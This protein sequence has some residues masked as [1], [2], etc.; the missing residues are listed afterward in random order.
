MSIGD[1]LKEVRERQGASQAEFGA[2]GGVQKQAQLKYEKGV[3]CPDA[4]YLAALVNAGVDV[5]YVLTGERWGNRQEVLAD[6]ISHLPLDGQ[7]VQPLLDARSSDFEVMA[8]RVKD[9]VLAGAAS[10]AEEKNRRTQ[11][12]GTYAAEP[13]KGNVTQFPV[14]SVTG[15]SWRELLVMAVDALHDAQL[16][17]P[18][19]KLAELVD[20]LM[21]LQ[22]S[23]AKL[24]RDTVTAQVRLV[25]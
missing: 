15:L 14:E 13:A 18:G 11:L 16:S 25:A 23:G 19:P 5:Y 21:A 1:R 2:L 17:L 9:A 7:F 20:L 22:R 24:D 4:A 3:R 6:F 12:P 10:E 8:R